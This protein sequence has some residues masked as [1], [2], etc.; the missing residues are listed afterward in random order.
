MSFTSDSDPSSAVRGAYG[1]GVCTDMW[2][3]S[4]WLRGWVVASD[5]LWYL[6]VFSKL[7]RS[8]DD[9]FITL[10]VLNVA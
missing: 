3:G 1:Q 10:T 8:C 5:T 6:C 4:G 2:A 7:G 9:P